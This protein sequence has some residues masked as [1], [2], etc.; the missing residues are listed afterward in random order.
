MFSAV[1]QV[2]HSH[3]IWWSLWWISAL[4]TE[5][6]GIMLGLVEKQSTWALCAGNS[7][8]SW[9]EKAK[10]WHAGLPSIVGKALL[11]PEVQLYKPASADTVT[12]QSYVT[13]SF[14]VVKNWP[15]NAGDTGNCEFDPW[16]WKIPWRRAWQPTPVFLP[17]E[18]HGQRS[19]AGCSSWGR[20]V[21]QDWATESRAVSTYSKPGKVEVWK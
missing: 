21:R 10:L 9:E 15:A 2:R 17:G 19:L 18:S 20:R 12:S 13:L 14:P 6:L 5:A 4:I 8:S 3:G 7:R 1:I 11:Y 16:V